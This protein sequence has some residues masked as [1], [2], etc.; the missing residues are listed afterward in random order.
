MMAY[1]DRPPIITCQELETLAGA[2]ALG[3][4]L[5][6]EVAAAR[7][8]LA[9]CP[10]PHRSVRELVATA[11]LLAEAVEPVEPPAGLRERILA[12]ARAA[13]PAP[14]PGVERPLRPGAVH[15]WRGLSVP[16]PRPVWL[17]AAAVLMLALGVAVWNVQLRRTLDRREAQLTTQQRVVDA[18]AR[19]ARV[20]PF[21]VAPG[22]GGARGAV[23]WE[24]GQPP[25]VV[26]EGLPPPP[27]GHV[28]QLWAIRAGRPEDI[29]M[30]FQPGADGRFLGAM[31]NL[32]AMEAVAVTV[33]AGRVP[34]PTGPPLLIAELTTGAGRPHLARQRVT[35]PSLHDLWISSPPH[36]L[37]RTSLAVWT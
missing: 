15:G 19:G 2:L 25:I 9:S 20:V 35:R 26:F 23:I 22:L 6:H 11:W 14:L 13:G 30:V 34:Q 7:E 27:A 32:P 18:V 24:A 12:A 28:Y 16:R 37:S 33:E 17:A 5:P 29:G 3:A 10:R 8:H 1:T 21:T 4:A 31:P 36:P